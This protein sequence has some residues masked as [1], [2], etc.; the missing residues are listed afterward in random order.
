LFGEPRHGYRD[1]RKN[2]NME[3]PAIGGAETLRRFARYL[4]PHTPHIIAMLLSTALFVVFSSSAYWLAASFLTALFNGTLAPAD[5]ATGLN[6]LLKHWTALLLVGPTPRATLTRAAVA[7]VIAFFGKN[8]FG[9]LQLFYISHVEQRVIKELRDQLFG[10]LLRQDLAFFQ[11]ERR[12][13]LISTV[14]NDVEQLNSALNKSFTKLVRDPINAFVLLVL[15]FAVSWKLTLAA[16]VVVPALGWIV[17]VLARRIKAHAVRVQ[18]IFARLTGHLQETISGVRIVKAF[19]NEPFETRRFQGHTGDLYRTMFAQERLR[20][21]VIPLNEVVGVLIISAILY[22]GGQLVLVRGSI[23]SE[24]FIR[25]LVLLFALLNPLLSLGNLMSNVRVAEASGARVFRVLDT[26]PEVTVP[27]EPAPVA[28]F[29]DAIR[30][31]NVSFRYTDDTPPVLRDIALEIGG[32]DHIAIVGRSGSGKST[33][34]NLLPRFFDP[35]EGRI[36]LDGRDLREVDPRELRRLFGMVTQQVILFHD[37]IRANIAYGLEGV[38]DTAI[39][40]AAKA[41]WAHDFIRTLPEGYDTI[42]GEQGALFSG[43]QRQRI[44]I[45]RALL[46]RPEIVLLDEATSALDPESEEAVAAALET[47]TRGRTVVTVTHRLAAVRGASRI[48]VIEEG[49]IVDQGSHEELLARCEVY[50]H[51]ARQQRLLAQDH[52]SAEGRA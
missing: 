27:A 14:L 17:Q 22:V 45:A 29:S 42:V 37:T 34:L 2:E 4:A 33:L 32:G 19:V 35:T 12:G 21:L 26:L 52:S 23:P 15:L 18:E 46:R 43:G 48:V 30:F 49:R 41:A 5:T 7:I 50:R 25:F 38:D 13:T 40:E 47:L 51:L 11:R 39:E 24:D 28:S 6:G 10:H 36:T 16:I 8:L 44:S 9:Y 1:M 20:R 31:E 3:T